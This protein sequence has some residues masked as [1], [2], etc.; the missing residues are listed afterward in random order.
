MTSFSSSLEIKDEDP[1]IEEGTPILAVATAGWSTVS[2]E[3]QKIL[4]KE[5]KE[6]CWSDDFFDDEDGVIA[7]FDF[8]YDG[9]VSFETRNGVFCGM[10]VSLFVLLV[11][12]PFALGVL[13]L[14]L[15]PLAPCFWRSQ[16]RW[17]A[18]AKHLAI[19][20]EGIREIRDEL[21]QNNQLLR[22]TLLH[23]QGGEGKQTTTTTTIAYEL[24]LSDLALPPPQLAMTTKK[25]P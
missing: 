1:D 9:I 19:T 14:G 20:Q 16:V 12:G 3:Y 8:D 17:K 21:R 22:N 5:T 24:E 10:V 18:E 25:E 11:Y 2:A 4:P 6:I 23:K 7:V 15:V 13:G